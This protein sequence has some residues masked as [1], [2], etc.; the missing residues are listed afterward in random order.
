MSESTA[1]LAPSAARI[2]GG[3]EMAP[4]LAGPKRAQ[5]SLRGDRILDM[6]TTDDTGLSG[7]VNRAA[8]TTT[9]SGCSAS[10]VR[11]MNGIEATNKYRNNNSSSNNV[12]DDDNK[13]AEVVNDEHERDDSSVNHK[14]SSDGGQRAISQEI[15]NSLPSD[16]KREKRRRRSRKSQ[17]NAGQTQDEPARLSRLLDLEQKLVQGEPAIAISERPSIASSNESSPQTGA[18]LISAR[19]RSS[20]ITSDYHSHSSPS[21][22]INLTPKYNNR[23]QSDQRQQTII[24]ENPTFVPSNNMASNAK[25]QQKPDA[26]DDR[27]GPMGR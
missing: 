23:G 4:A 19:E 25:R 2:G 22:P 24:Y 1:N 12:D 5:L 7:G 27:E 3:G 9:T 10:F 16:K 13:R 17:Q 14:F 6:R 11:E 8:T 21:H 26:K 18:K 20:S 15:I